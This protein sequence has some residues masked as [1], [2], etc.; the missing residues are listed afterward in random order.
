LRAILPCSCLNSS[1]IIVSV[2]SLATSLPS[3]LKDVHFQSS[4]FF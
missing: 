2:T 4:E 3:T 1:S